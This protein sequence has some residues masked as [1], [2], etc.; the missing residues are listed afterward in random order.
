MLSARKANLLVLVADEFD[1]VDR[2]TARDIIK[3]IGLNTDSD[4][5]D[6]LLIM[7][8]LENQKVR[9]QMG[10]NLEPYIAEEEIK[11]YIYTA[12][13]T[14]AKSPGEAIVKLLDSFSFLLVDEE[15]LKLFAEAG[16]NP[17]SYYAYLS[18]R[19]NYPVFFDNFTSGRTYAIAYLSGS[20][21]TNFWERT[22]YWFRDDINWHGFFQG[23]SRNYIF[24]NFAVVRLNDVTQY[25]VVSSW[26]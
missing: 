4:N 5:L 15:R 25:C 26:G 3:R 24:N 7:V 6:A 16:I 19:Q 13:G 9:V 20:D 18:N 22:T 23:Y 11:N 14:D 12:F 17:R 21:N 1:S 10:L 8:D 2:S